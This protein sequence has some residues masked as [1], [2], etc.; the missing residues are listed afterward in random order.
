MNKYPFKFLD[1]YDQSDADIFFGRDEEIQELY[2]MVVGN[3]IVLVYGA[4]GTGK[5]SLIQCGLANKFRS[6]DWLPITIRRVDNINESVINAMMNAGG[7]NEVDDDEIILGSDAN[8]PDITK[9]IRGVCLTCFK[10]IYL[11]FDQFEEIFIM[12][13]NE[14]QKQFF[15]TVRQILQVELPIKV[16][17]SIRE[18]YL[19]HLGDFERIVPQLFH[20]K[21]RI[22]PINLDKVRQ[23]IVGITRHM[24]SNVRLNTGETD[25]IV[26]TIFDRIRGKHK[27]LNIDLSYLQ[28]YLDT[29]YLNITKDN[30]RQIEAV[31]TLDALKKIGDIG[32][33]L[34]NFLKMQVTSISDN[35]KNKFPEISPAVIWKILNPFVTLEGTKEP[36]GKQNL[37]RIATDIQPSLIGATIEAFVHS[38]ILRYTE[39]GNL[40]EIAHDS[41][42]K[43]INEQRTA[44]ERTLLEIQQLIKVH[45]SVN[46]SARELFSEK[47]LMFFEPYLSRLYLTDEERKFI[48]ESAK[49]NKKKKWQFWK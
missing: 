45:T 47:Q 32:D 22:E 27:T 10:P 16:I 4:S 36:I 6:Y 24:N 44:E 48:D 40:Y 9:L 29:L 13:S 33:V 49:A 3:S 28:V 12:S 31:I 23:I 20:K 1:A 37:S 35:L 11:I 18:E 2:D 7:N 42:A 19:G 8:L 43:S 5:T 25:M 41:L 15:E 17:F 30:T 21:L 38:R 14:E 34:S 46:A 39:D 26:E